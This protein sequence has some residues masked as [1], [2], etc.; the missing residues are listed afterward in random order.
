MISYCHHNVDCLSVCPSVTLHC[1]E[2]IHP[3]EKVS[4]QAKVP[5]YRNNDRP[6]TFK[7]PPSPT[8]GPYTPQPNISKFV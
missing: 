4:E 3:T 6:T 8:L 7:Q 1:G 2:A 5:S